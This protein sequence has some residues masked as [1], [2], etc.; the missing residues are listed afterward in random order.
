MTLYY[1]TYNPK[2]IRDVYNALEDGIFRDATFGRDLTVTRNLTVLGTFTMGDAAVDTFTCEGDA[3]FNADVTFNLGST[4]AFTLT[5]TDIS[6]PLVMTNTITTAAKTGGRALFHTKFNVAVGAWIN[7]LKGYMEITGTS[8]YTS[9]L[10]S[11]V[12]AEMKFAAKAGLSGSYYPL[13]VEVVC[14]A[15]F[16]VAGDGGSN[17][18]FIYARVSGTTDNWEDEAWFMRVVD[19]TAASGNMLSANSQT[20]RCAFGTQGTPVERYMVFSQAVDSLSLS[21]CTT[22]ITL[23]GAQTTGISITATG[24]TDGI[25]ISGTTPV[26]GLEISSACTGSAINVTG[27]NTGRA[28]RIG[29]KTSA[30]TSLTISSGETVDAEP[31]NNYLFG[32]FTKVASSEATSTDELRSAWIR[33]RVNEGCHVGSGAGWGYGVCGAEIQ[34]KVYADSAATNMYSWQNSAVWAQLETQGASGVNFKSG[35]VSSCVLANVGL[36]STTT[37]DNG[38]VVAGVTVNSNTAG[39]GVTDTGGFYGI[40]IYQDNS[41]CL[42]FQTG[43][44]LDDD[45]ATTGID[46]GNATT[47]INMGTYTGS[48]IVV[49]GSLKGADIATTISGS[50]ALDANKFTVTDSTT[51]SGATYSRGLYLHAT[52]SGTKTTNGEFNALSVDLVTS[53]SPQRVSALNLYTSGVASGKTVVNYNAI[54]IYM[55]ND[56]SGATALSG[57]YAFC[58]LIDNTS[59][60]ATKSG[61]FYI[62]SSGGTLESIIY[63]PNTSSMATNFFEIDGNTATAPVYASGCNVSGAGA[64]EA[65]LR[66]DVGG[67]VYGLPL[68]AI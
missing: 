22:G 28:L 34:L 63:C 33:T 50:S 64:S 6:A 42:D 45:V 49:E 41:G 16:S 66:V 32:L 23:S 35:S 4:E 5:C 54:E 51:N 52:T 38:A 17:A 26:D 68:I 15:T 7:A 21:G 44:H 10:A 27:T 30:A 65:Y 43:I 48:A 67:T 12:V 25:K 40:Y 14:P 13:E 3:I 29:T 47:G 36:T 8:G 2:H 62:R 19:L 37:I 59:A 39:S 31:A 61:F 58:A 53:G 55:D 18:G 56:N 20:L 1:S 46:L 9:G 11:A 60:K 24:L 57:K